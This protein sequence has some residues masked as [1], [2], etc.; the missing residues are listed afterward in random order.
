MDT[1]LRAYQHILFRI[2][3]S[4]QKDLLQSF[5][6]THVLSYPLDLEIIKKP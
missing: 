2:F 6:K 3:Q 4:D 5:S 1:A